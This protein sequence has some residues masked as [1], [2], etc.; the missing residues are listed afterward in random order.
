MKNLFPL[1]LSA[2]FNLLISAL[3]LGTVAS[4]AGFMM[5]RSLEQDYRRLLAHVQAIAA[6]GAASTEYALYTHNK[7]EIARQLRPLTRAPEVMRITL[8]DMQ[9]QILAAWPAE[10]PEIAP[11]I[12][13]QA[14]SLQY[15]LF[16]GG[17]HWLEIDVPIL[18]ASNSED[19]GSLLL[20]ADRQG[21]VTQLGALRLAVSLAPFRQEA[22]SL[23]SFTLM[24]LAGLV[25]LGG[26]G[27]A[28]ISRR[29]VITPLRQLGEAAH[30]VAEG[31]LQPVH[32]AATAPEVKALE[33]DF[34][35]MTERLRVY[36]ERDA[37]QL[38][39]LEKQV[40]S[41]TE[42][43]RTA[44]EQ[45]EYSAQVAKAASEAKTQFLATISHELRTPLNVILGFNELLIKSSLPPAQIRYAE[46]VQSS[47]RHLL[48]LINQILDVSKL[49]SGRIE[50]K[51]EVFDLRELLDELAS[52][53]TE[54]AKRASIYLHVALI[55]DHALQVYADR[56]RLRQVLFNLIGNAFKFTQRGGITV[57]IDCQL[58]TPERVRCLF[59]VEDTGIGIP[60]AEQKRIFDRFTQADETITRRFG[61]TG[62]GLAIV[63]Q[64]VTLM[65]G[66]IHVDSEPDRGSRF[67]FTLELARPYVLPATISNETVAETPVSETANLELAG[68][69]SP[70]VLLAED[71][72]LNQIL[73]REML[74]RLGCQVSVAENGIATLMALENTR[75][76]LLLLDCHMPLMDGFSVAQ[77]LRRNEKSLQAQRR[78]PI[79]AL[80]ADA[81]AG[82]RERC[83][84]AGMDAYLS[85]PF[86]Y[87]ELEAI[88]LHWIAWSAPATD[89]P[90]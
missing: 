3:L 42:A 22:Q 52:L 23:L 43:L 29:V 59:E 18:G 47:G 64:L 68:G 72:P 1:S 69:S 49:E 71:M 37:H 90:A 8:Q 60:T 15:L 65:G 19:G 41:R 53:F 38:E 35:I 6:M 74:E 26:V 79:I 20:A 82:T 21:S 13:N 55:P 66:A 44:L 88:L 24:M 86:S 28:V 9:N 80:T 78:L 27:T 87:E 31:R 75:F 57:K 5:Y 70:R 16:I 32:I 56:L 83:I 25:V 58:E 11:E 61:G 81:M 2:R 54:Q 73:T 48:E 85:K 51:P 36:R 39:T 46:L 33:T 10:A 4:L 12:H 7:D 30:G 17:E 67:Y 89:T 62:L 40:A 45:A 76:D 50:L 63:E 84:Q 77:E 34:N 14:P